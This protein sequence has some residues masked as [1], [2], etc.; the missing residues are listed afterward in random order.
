MV[1]PSKDLNYFDIVCLLGH[2]DIA[3]LMVKSGSVD[4]NG[5]DEHGQTPLFHASMR[6]M[7]EVVRALAEA[8]ADLNQAKECGATPLFLASEQGHV[9]VVRCLAEAGACLLYTS[10]SPRD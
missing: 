5:K 1:Y 7:I 8:G 6:G 2:R 4:I 9:D 10:P 3:L